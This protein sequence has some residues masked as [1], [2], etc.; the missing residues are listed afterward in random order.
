M[1]ATEIRWIPV[2]TQINTPK[3]AGKQ[4]KGTAGKKGQTEDD[5][6]REIYSNKG[7]C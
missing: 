1:S 2:Q 6:L 4:A 7:L 5:T 3:Q